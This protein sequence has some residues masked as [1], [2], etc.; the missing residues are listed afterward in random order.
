VLRYDVNDFYASGGEDHDLHE[1]VVDVVTSWLVGA[2]RRGVLDAVGYTLRGVFSRVTAPSD[3]VIAP[4]KDDEGSFEDGDDDG[5]A[6]SKDTQ[7]L[8]PSAT[9]KYPLYLE[10]EDGQ[11]YTIM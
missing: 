6:P 9:L 11:F 1:V 2:Y 5:G 8:G 7:V 4:S 10:T 3:D